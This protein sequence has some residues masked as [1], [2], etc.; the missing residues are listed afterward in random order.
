[1]IG[2]VMLGTNQL[3]EACSFYDAL[4]SELGYAR[5]LEGDA[6]V[7]WG[8]SL[9]EPCLSVTVPHDG[10]SASAGNGNMLALRMET[11]AQVDSLYAKALSLGAADAGPPGPRGSGFYAGYFRD[12]DGN[13][14]NA[15][16]MS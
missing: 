4:M 11:T 10:Q 6:F 7:T 1:M 15:F 9:L 14:L 12:L 16:A 3:A 5:V 2:Y 13:K 8:E